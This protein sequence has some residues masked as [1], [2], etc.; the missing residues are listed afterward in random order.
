MLPTSYKTQ[1]SPR[2][3]NEPSA[4]A[5]KPRSRITC[6]VPIT[7]LH[8]RKRN[9]IKATYLKSSYVVSGKLYTPEIHWFI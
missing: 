8:Y 2:A 9:L 3:K 1:D 4:G 6:R 7:W 5:E